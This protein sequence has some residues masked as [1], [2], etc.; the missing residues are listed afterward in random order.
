VEF[1]VFAY[2][3]VL[4]ANSSAAGIWW[5]ISN[6][7]VRNNTFVGCHGI[8]PG[9]A[10]INGSKSWLGFENNI[11]SHTTGGAA[12][13]DYG[14]GIIYGYPCNLFWENAGGNYGQWEISPTDLYV[15]PYYCGL[16]ELNFT[17]R[18]DSPAIIGGCGQIGALGIG[19]EG[20]SIEPMSWGKIKGLY[21]L[22]R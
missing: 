3:S 21:R 12:V 18:E 2:D 11:V 9:A 6:G 1:N 19:C 4:A 20:V 22:E 8:L 5:V 16:E 15:D 13:Q 7:H 17:V 14:G 10:F